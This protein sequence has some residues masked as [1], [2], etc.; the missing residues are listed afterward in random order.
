[1]KNF[2]LGFKTRGAEELAAPQAEIQTFIAV[3]L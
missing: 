1:L 3:E 2:L